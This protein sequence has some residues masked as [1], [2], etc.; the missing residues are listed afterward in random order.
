MRI[1]STIY[2][3]WN[4]CG[5][6]LQE[7]SRH[8][9]KATIK[10]ATPKPAKYT[11]MAVSIGL[12]SRQLNLRSIRLSAVLLI[13]RSCVLS[14]QNTAGRQKL[15]LALCDE[16]HPASSLGMAACPVV[17]LRVNSNHSIH[18]RER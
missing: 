15:Q 13:Y 10:T 6:G 8:T 11:I 12:R 1:A 7:V 4:F 16:T 14:H 18:P 5:Y 9:A 3:G 2:D 17:P